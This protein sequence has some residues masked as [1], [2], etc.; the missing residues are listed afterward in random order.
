MPNNDD[1]RESFK[2]RSAGQ[3]LAVLRA[4]MITPLA[5]I[6]GNATLL[7]RIN[8]ED[9]STFPKDY[10]VMVESILQAHNNLNSV[11]DALTLDIPDE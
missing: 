6:Q 11:L 7:A 9:S 3:R 5:V 4:E 8:L 2:N 1:L 10:S